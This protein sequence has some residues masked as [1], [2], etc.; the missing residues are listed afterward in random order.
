MATLSGSITTQNLVGPPTDKDQCKNGG[1]QNYPFP[2]Q[3][4]CV[5]WVNHNT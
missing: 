4:E 3:G 2:N 1:W 5:V